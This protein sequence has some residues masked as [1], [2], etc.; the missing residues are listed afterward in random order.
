MAQMDPETRRE[1]SSRHSEAGVDTVSAVGLC[2][3][4][5]EHRDT[6]SRTFLLISYCVYLLPFLF[7][8]RKITGSKVPIIRSFSFIRV[9][10]LITMNRQTIA[11]VGRGVG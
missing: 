7:H 5:G 9:F 11:G 8:S 10:S 2:Q 4:S 1:P 3:V 6:Y